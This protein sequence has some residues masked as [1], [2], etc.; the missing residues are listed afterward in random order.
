MRRLPEGL[1]EKKMYKCDGCA[2]RLA[3]GQQPACVQNCTCGALEFGPIE[4]LRA[5]YPKAETKDFKWLKKEFGMAGTEAVKPRL[6]IVP[7]G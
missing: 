6:V 3:K 7:L 4:E 2:S 5:K 1:S